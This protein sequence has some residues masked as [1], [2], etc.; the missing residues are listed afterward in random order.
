MGAFDDSLHRHR[1]LRV[2]YSR[3]IFKAST[4]LRYALTPIR[5]TGKS[6]RALR[7]TSAVFASQLQLL[8]STY[9]GDYFLSVRPWALLA[10]KIKQP[11]S[12]VS[13]NRAHLLTWPICPNAQV[14]II[15]VKRF[16]EE[17]SPRLAVTDS[18]DRRNLRLFQS[19]RLGR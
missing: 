11:D 19:R 2:L 13:E 18:R 5:L 10:K 4:P 7:W 6:S 8:Y 9:S 3:D 15:E 14:T 1:L 17:L 16:C 12:A